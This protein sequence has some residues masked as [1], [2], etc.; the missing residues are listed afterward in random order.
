MKWER[1]VGLRFHEKIGAYKDSPIGDVELSVAFG[2]QGILASVERTDGGHDWFILTPLEMLK[3]LIEHY[4]VPVP[5]GER[6]ER[7]GTK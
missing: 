7:G 3:G 2:D 5:E 1:T 4:G 6:C